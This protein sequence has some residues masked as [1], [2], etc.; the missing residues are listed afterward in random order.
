MLGSEVP[1]PARSH[2]TAPRSK[3]GSME[4]KKN[5]VDGL[6]RRENRSVSRMVEKQE[7]EMLVISDDDLE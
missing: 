6:R 2:Q 5:V 1:T 7:M 4:R 3:N